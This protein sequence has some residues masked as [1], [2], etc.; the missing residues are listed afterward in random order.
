MDALSH[1]PHPPVMHDLDGEI[2]IASVKQAVRSIRNFSLLVVMESRQKFSILG[3]HL[4]SRSMQFAVALLGLASR[5][6]SRN[7]Q[8]RCHCY[9]I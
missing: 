7:I 6:A 4:I 1:F 5:S 3:R 9:L 2:F 8:K